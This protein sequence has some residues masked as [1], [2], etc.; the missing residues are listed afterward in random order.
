MS[1]LLIA[2]GVLAIGLVLLFGL[3]LFLKGA[4]NVQMAL[5]STTWPKTS[6]TVLR[7]DTTRNVSKGTKRSA[8]SVTF[9][10]KTVIRYA[11]NGQEY[12]TDVLHF[13]QTLGSSDKSE[14]AL[15]R[16]RFPEGKEVPVSYNPRNPSAAVMKPGLHADAFW[17][18]GAGFAFLLPAALLL[19]MGPSVLRGIVADDRDFANS[20]DRAIEAARR[21]ETLPDR[22]FPPPRPA[23]G[24]AAMAVA[25]AVFGAV[26]CSLG[27]LALTAGL[28]RAWHGSAS[29]QWP[30]TQGVVIFARKGGGDDGRDATD[31]TTDPAYYARFVYQ[32]EV[33]GT[34]H[35]NNVRQFAQ[36]EGGSSEEAQRI[37]S[38]YRK[39]AGVK[40]SYFPTDP[41]VAVLEPGNTGAALWLPGIGVVL[42]LFSL[43]VFI[44]VVPS[45]AR[46]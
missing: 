1:K 19:I 25:A 11:V 26:A 29:V 3:Y 5:A 15:Q 32:Y 34:K 22:D 14:A 35:F 41:D 12:T 6:G 43:A 27:L 39:G 38:R 8:A 17:L 4:H 13:G 7:S 21:G 36:V 40:V 31:D 45:I 30:T 33:S 2:I 20:V 44:W 9:S 24:D 37:E 18:P 23:G 10:T 42:I 28:Q 46:P 16:L